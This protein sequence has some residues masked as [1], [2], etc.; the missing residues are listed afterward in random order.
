VARRQVTR[1]EQSGGS[2]DDL[3]AAPVGVGEQQRDLQHAG[4][5]AGQAADVQ[6]GVVGRAKEQR[7]Q[8]PADLGDGGQRT[9]AR[10]GQRGARDTQQRIAGPLDGRVVHLGAGGVAQQ[11]GHQG[12]V[13]AL[14]RL[15]HG[16]L[17]VEP[18]QGTEILDRPG[19]WQVETPAGEKFPMACGTCSPWTRSEITEHTYTPTVRELTIGSIGWEQEGAVG[20]YRYMAHETGVGSGTV[21]DE[22][23]LCETE[24]SALGVARLL[25]H[26]AN[27]ERDARV[28]RNRDEEKRKARRKPDPTKQENLRLTAKVRDLEKL[29]AT[30]QVDA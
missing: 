21:Y 18:R 25:A 27:Q 11:L 29:V 20:R 17:A 19:S 1:N 16:H 10:I 24:E 14:P 3:V 5:A 2:G 28:Q 26:Q 13:R 7:V 22:N 8:P 6:A 23:R 30:L 9:I 4:E 12:V 15:L